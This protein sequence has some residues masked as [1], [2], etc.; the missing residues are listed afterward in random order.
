MIHRWYARLAAADDDRGS[1]AVLS[2]FIVLIAATLAAFLADAGAQIQ[3]ANH[4]DTSAAEAARAASIGIGPV[5]TAD[6]TATRRAAQAARTY[7]TKAGATG[8]VRVLGPATVT[9]TVTVTETTPLLG[10]SISQTRTHTAQLH[11]GVHTGE[12]AP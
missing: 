1:V 5:P 10:I 2:C 6:G 4:A 7:L 8:T 9:I 12:P 3:A 11:I